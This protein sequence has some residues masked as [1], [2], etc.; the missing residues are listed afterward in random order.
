M[1]EELCL[2][3]LAQRLAEIATQTQEP[4]TAARLMVLVNEVLASA[5]LGPGPQG[6]GSAADS[7]RA[8]RGRAWLAAAS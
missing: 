6:A 7:R 4:D 5:G 3:A 2:I 1:A 8:G